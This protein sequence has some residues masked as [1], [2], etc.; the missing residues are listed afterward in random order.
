MFSTLHKGRALQWTIVPPV[1]NAS[2]Q[3][4]LKT[5]LSGKWLTGLLCRCFLY[6]HM[7]IIKHLIPWPTLLL[8]ALVLM[9]TPEKFIR[10]SAETAR[11]CRRSR[12][13]HLVQQYRRVAWVR[14]RYSPLTWTGTASMASIE[15]VA[16]A[17]TIH[18]DLHFLWI[19]SYN[20]QGLSALFVEITLNSPLQNSLHE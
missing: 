7:L 9:G 11:C 3:S 15:L 17:L 10:L 12:W 8:D 16:S 1:A 6:R 5:H 18:T 4:S 14:E 19:N 2:H 20:E 13:A